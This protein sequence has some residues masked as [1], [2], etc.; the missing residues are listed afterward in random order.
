MMICQRGM[1]SKVPRLINMKQSKWD[2]DEFIV[3]LDLYMTSRPNPPGPDSVECKLL[4]NFLRLRAISN[5]TKI[6]SKFRNPN[7]VSMQ[8]QNIR[9]LDQRFTGR[10]LR[11]TSKIGRHIWNRYIFNPR[12]L[13]RHSNRIIDNVEF[14]IVNSND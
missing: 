3:A 10:G 14:N 7:G 4:S 2:E 6:N 9:K 8:L 11:P 13:R 12:R 1:I 5:G